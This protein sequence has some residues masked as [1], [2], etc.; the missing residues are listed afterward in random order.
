LSDFEAGT[1]VSRDLTGE[2]KGKGKRNIREKKDPRSVV[3]GQ[4]L[5]THPPPSPPSAG[6]RK[7][8]CAAKGILGGGSL[9]TDGRVQGP[10]A[11]KSPAEAGP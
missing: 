4:I 1:R 11:K 10:G 2:G 3:G 8:G 9:L 7:C 5:G 6:G